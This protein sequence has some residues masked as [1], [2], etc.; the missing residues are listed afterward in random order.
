L[1]F[2][3]KIYP[4]VAQYD[5]GHA[6]FNSINFFF[7]FFLS[8]SQTLSALFHPQIF[9]L[10]TLTLSHSSEVNQ[11]AFHCQRKKTHQDEF[12]KSILAE[13]SSI[14]FPNANITFPAAFL[15]F[16]HFHILPLLL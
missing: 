6:P 15:P 1:P 10:P 14:Y 12:E 7:F 2:F 13:D 8:F 16:I 4:S 9:F 11:R 3:S 5:Y